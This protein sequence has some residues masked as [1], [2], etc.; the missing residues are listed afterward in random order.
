MPNIASFI[1]LIC[2]G[3]L[4]GVSYLPVVVAVGLGV[5]HPSARASA[6]A[7]MCD[8]YFS[9]G[10]VLEQ[11]PVAR[12][13]AQQA[14]GLMKQNDVGNGMLFEWEIEEQRAFWMRNTWVPLSIG[15]FS[16]D[17]TLFAIKDMEP[18]TDDYHFSGR[19]A[20]DALEL[21]QGEFERK[22]LVVGSRLTRRVCGT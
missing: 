13:Q 7:E 18:E 21:A 3:R 15:F 6:E 8:L 1:R 20:Q 5:G 19:P 17:G 11:V 9:G 2:G 14:R 22:G 16:A 4:S 12:T 10:V